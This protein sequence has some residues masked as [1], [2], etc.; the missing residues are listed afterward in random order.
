M[1]D[2][3]VIAATNVSKGGRGEYPSRYV[4]LKWKEGTNY[5][6]YSRHMQVFD[7]V[8]DEYYIYGHYHCSLKDAIKDMVKSMLDNNKSYCEGNVS[9][10]PG[11]DMNI[12]GY[13]DKGVW[14]EINLN[15]YL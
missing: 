4:V 1:S 7:G 2:T 10:I 5:H 13:F 14:I 11:V 15:E 12:H 6:P 8:H 9:H 3:T